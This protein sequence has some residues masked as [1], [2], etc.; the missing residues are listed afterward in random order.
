MINNL[1]IIFYYLLI[2]LKKICKYLINLLK[3]HIIYYDVGMI[4]NSNEMVS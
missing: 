1:S 4:L 3:I 2:F